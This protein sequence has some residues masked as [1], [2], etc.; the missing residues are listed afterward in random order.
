M[1]ISD[2]PAQFDIHAENEE[3][4]DR[5]D[6]RPDIWYVAGACLAMTDTAPIARIDPFP[7]QHRVSDLMT[8]HV[9]ILRSTDS[10]EAAVKAMAQRDASAALILDDAGRPAG[11]VTE[12]DVLKRIASRSEGALAVPLADVMSVPVA[13]VSADTFFYLAIAIAG[14]VSGSISRPGLDKQAPKG[15]SFAPIRGIYRPA[16]PL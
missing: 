4:P 3:D 8:T 14:L 7:F 13:L 15:S 5:N 1:P 10:L 2:I 6:C 12:H 9:P 16:A 11:I